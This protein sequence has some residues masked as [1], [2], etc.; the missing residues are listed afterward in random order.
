MN[1]RHVR[2]PR[3]PLDQAKLDE[4]A[5]SYVGRFATTRAKL[6]SY[7]QRKLRERGWAGAG[8]DGAGED[9]AGRTNVAALVERFD[10]SGLVDDGAYAMAKA[11]TLTRRGYGKRRLAVALRSA[12]VNDEAGAPAL[13]HAEREAASAALRFAERRRFGPYAVS[14]PSDARDRSK[15]RDKQ[16]AAMMRAGHGLTLALTILRLEPGAIPDPGELMSG[17]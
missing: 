17:G 12:G 9:S 4:L 7:L 8:E 16:L 13:D 5:L 1:P 2:K 10:R 14:V 3:P 6:A 15:L 11:E